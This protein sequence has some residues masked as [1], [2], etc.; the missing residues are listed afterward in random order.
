MMSTV[1]SNRGLLLCRQRGGRAAPHLYQGLQVRHH[2]AAG[3]L[4]CPHRR[5]SDRPHRAL[6]SE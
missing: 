1:R 4:G 6:P 5:D 3:A 2:V